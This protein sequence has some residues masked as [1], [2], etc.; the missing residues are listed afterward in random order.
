M[1]NTY[2]KS[3]HRSDSLQHSLT[4]KIDSLRSLQLP[5]QHFENKYDSIK[6]KQAQVTQHFTGR[7]DSL[8]KATIA[9]VDSISL[10]PELKSHLQ[11]Y[12][13]KLNG[14]GLNTN[15]ALPDVNIPGLPEVDLA[16]PSL[17]EIG[18][19][20]ALNLPTDVNVPGVDLPK[21]E[22]DGIKDIGGK[23]GEVA[24]TAK[25]L[26]ETNVQEAQA[27]A[28]K[29][30]EQQAAK[31]G[32]VGDLKKQTEAFDKMMPA[33]SEEEAKA[34]LV[35]QGK[36]MAIDHFAGKGDALKG[37][38]EKVAKYKEKYSSVSSL[39]DLKKRPRNP[40]KEKP[41]IE[42]IVPGVSFQYQ[43][44]DDYLLDSYIYTG[45]K[46]TPRLVSG[47]GWNQRVAR[48][49]RNA[50]WNQ[51]AAIFGPRAYAEYRV[52]RGFIAHAEGEVMNT[53][54]PYSLTAAKE[55]SRQWVWGMMMGLKTEY[56]I[57]RW[58]KGTVLIQYN[59]FN[60]HHKAP[61]VDR[62]NSRLGFEFQMKKRRR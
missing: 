27:L 45:Y 11:E 62:L 55:G 36:E 59:L 24:S 6:Q 18:N 35:E 39:E 10:P 46:H 58:M 61:Y 38:M 12:T 13:A 2:Q 44:R 28:S 26:S 56:K 1:K 9:K 23:A 40:L 4:A 60:R 29:E 7:L 50:Y 41:F 52:Y 25:T 42:R 34:Q 19:S 17:K 21:A 54:V 49:Q 33:A 47:L 5:T 15:V 22:L 37:A 32:G 8:K 3:R 14:V 48:D 31:I 16:L 30:A 43:R 20:D 53:F 57:T 51:R